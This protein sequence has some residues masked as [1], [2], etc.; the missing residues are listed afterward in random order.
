MLMYR[1][2]GVYFEWLDTRLSGIEPVRTDIAGFVGVAARGPLH[3]PMKVESWSQFTSTFG[4][5]TPQGYL[6][7]AV[8][9]F[10]VNGGQ[11]CW[12]VRSADPA[13]AIPAQL[14]LLDDTAQ[15]TLRLTASSPGT[16]GQEVTVSVVRLGADRFSLI[17]SL[18]DGGQELWRNLSMSPGDA[19]YV[20]TVL[21][22][23]GT[24]SRLVQVE[25]LHS[26]AGFPMNTP[27]LQGLTGQG[28][29]GRLIGGQDGLATLGVQ[30]LSGD[31]APPDQRWGLATLED[32]DEV[33]IVA[34]PDIMP[35]ISVPGRRKERQPRCDVLEAESFPPSTPGRLP[36]LPPPF[37]DEQIHILQSALII[38]CE[39][40]K[41]RIA[42]LDSQ[43]SDISPAQV[44]S[45]RKQ[46]STSYAAL[47]YPW[48][49]VLDPGRLAGILRAVPPSGHVAGVYA[50]TDRRLGVHK[51]PANEVVEGARDVVAATDDTAHGDLNANEVNAIRSY[52]GRGIRVAGART[53]SNDSAWRYINVRRLLIMI[54]EAI[55]EGTQWAV[56]EP[57]N[58]ALWSSLDRVARSFL[59]DLWRRG[60]LDGA[61]AEEAYSVRCDETTN[62]PE[63]TGAGR[64]I[65]L[66]GVQ[67]PWPAEFVIVRI[68]KTGGSTTILETQGT[69]NA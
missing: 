32:I 48:L 24:G 50:R 14:T 9:G 64:M 62:P 49:W 54:E 37:D 25:D 19:D 7:Y 68:G 12:V 13:Q 52:A 23:A 40:L 21:N 20:E 42:I 4:G 1:T 38:Q 29:I 5:H 43:P 31:G 17:L 28:P 30:H 41:D 39:K 15:P 22:A 44:L 16:W 53:L 67:P 27:N 11:T 65:C 26:P 8:E 6:A 66:I 47:Y 34:M 59:D 35:K 18:G 56:F 3:Q 2:P 33:S 46:F 60:M 61:S 45:R 51:P 69:N 57:N 55:D 36:E 58:P 10:F 63:E